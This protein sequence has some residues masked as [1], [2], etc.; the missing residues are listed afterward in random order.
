MMV[1]AAGCSRS[2]PAPDLLIAAQRALLE[3]DAQRVEELAGKIPREA[4][5]WQ[6]GH[7]RCELSHE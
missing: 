5:E 3:S 2:V 6:A 4:D 7:F 1:T